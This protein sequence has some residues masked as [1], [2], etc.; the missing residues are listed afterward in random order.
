M[1]TKD[2]TRHRATVSAKLKQL[3]RFT[4]DAVLL[5]GVLAPHF[6]AFFCAGEYWCNHLP[7]TLLL[8]IKR[9]SQML[10]KVLAPTLIP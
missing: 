1:A 5:Q 8:L 7:K 6:D 10:L 4:V 9:V 2:H 3:A